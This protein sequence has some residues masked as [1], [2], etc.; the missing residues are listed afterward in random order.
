MNKPEGE[1]KL[2]IPRPG[3]SSGMLVS[4]GMIGLS[5]DANATGRCSSYDGLAALAIPLR[6]GGGEDGRGWKPRAELV[7][8]VIHHILGEI[9]ES[10]AVLLQ[11][12]KNERFDRLY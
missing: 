1:T 4:R 2:P 7:L 8:M 11:N 3:R 12:Q 5:C 9:I 6:D 10:I